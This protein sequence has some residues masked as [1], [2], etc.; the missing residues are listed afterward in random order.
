M[1]TLKV[2]QLKSQQYATILNEMS[3]CYFINFVPPSEAG[4]TNEIDTFLKENFGEWK[5]NYDLSFGDAI[6]DA[7]INEATPVLDWEPNGDKKLA[8]D[9]M[10]LNWNEFQSKIEVIELT[11][12]TETI[13]S[14]VKNVEGYT[15][16]GFH[17]TKSKKYL[18]LRK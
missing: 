8:W 3:F 9:Q 13:D 4:V 2:K 5:E 15:N 11:V 18:S 1:K 7:L 6:M 16:M 10:L 17:I 12:S 14:Y